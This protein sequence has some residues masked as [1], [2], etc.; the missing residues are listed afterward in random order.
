MA[1]TTTLAAGRLRH[2]ISIQRLIAIL[3]SNGDEAQ[4]D[5]G[6]ALREWVEIALVW[7]AIE[8]LSAREFIQS[9]ATQAEVVAR[10]TIRYRSDIK[11]TDRLVHIKNGTAETYFNIAG[12]LGDRDSGLEYL[13]IPVSAG[14]NDGT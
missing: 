6:E 8:P 12:L 2:Q 11:P 4:A 5:N 1:G 14:V 13:T 10:V 3:D 9:N 7:A